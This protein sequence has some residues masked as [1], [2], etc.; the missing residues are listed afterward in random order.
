MFNKMINWKGNQRPIVIMLSVCIFSMV[1]LPFTNEAPKVWTTAIRPEIDNDQYE[2]LTRMINMMTNRNTTPSKIL[3]YISK[4]LP[5]LP[6]Q[7]KTQIMY[8]YHA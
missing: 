5:Y 4:K 8:R 3:D 6:P 2:E 1:L 7:E